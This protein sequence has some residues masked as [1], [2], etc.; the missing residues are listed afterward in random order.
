LIRRGFL[1]G[2][3]VDISNW[4]LVAGLVFGSVSISSASYVW[5]RQQKFGAGG[6]TLCI[7]AITLIGLPFWSSLRFEV[8]DTGIKA[9]FER[10][11][12]EIQQVK[13]ATAT[14]SQEV[15]KVAQSVEVNKREFV[16]LTERL[17]TKRVDPASLRNLRNSVLKAP[18]PD[19]GRLE[20]TTRTLQK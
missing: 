18:R 5:I 14:T 2:G 16:E 1:N 7:A 13:N 19:I 17:E 6:A 12:N 8:S 3:A 4:A 10:L 15:V 11:R 9:E 20:A